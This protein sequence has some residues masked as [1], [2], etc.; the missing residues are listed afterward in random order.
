MNLN[1]FAFGRWNK[2]TVKKYGNILSTEDQNIERI[3]IVFLC[4]F[5]YHL[6][7]MHNKFSHFHFNVVYAEKK[8]F[9]AH[10]CS[11]AKCCQNKRQ[12]INFSA[13]VA[14]YVF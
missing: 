5:I 12:P 7:Y 9:I 1:D 13:R 6:T 10:F 8:T 14:F 4:P 11:F 3:T 2:L